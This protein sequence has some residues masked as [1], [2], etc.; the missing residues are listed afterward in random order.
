MLQLIY[1]NNHFPFIW[2]YC[3]IFQPCISL[4]VLIVNRF[5]SNIMDLWVY[6]T[7]Y[8]GC[9]HCLCHLM[10]RKWLW[11]LNNYYPETELSRFLPCLVEISEFVSSSYQRGW[12]GLEVWLYT[13]ETSPKQFLNK[14]Q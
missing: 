11:F 9:T 13:N 7:S 2:I 10:K 3:H 1:E 12:F 4:N 6:A 14:S 5:K 8:W